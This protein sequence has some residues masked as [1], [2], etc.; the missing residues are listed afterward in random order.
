MISRGQPKT[1]EGEFS[2]MIVEGT[3]YEE[4]KNAGYVILESCRAMRS[5]NKVQMVAY[6]GFNM[7]LMFNALSREYECILKH[8]LSYTVS[9]G[10]DV[11]GNITRLDNALSGIEKKL[12]NNKLELENLIKQEANTREEVKKPFPREQELQEKRVRLN[13][14][15]ALLDVDKKEDEIVNEDLFEDEIPQWESQISDREL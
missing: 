5:P 10:D 15:N 13:E 1:G 6:K 2:G 14:L 11:F 3:F 12:S 4:K 7:Y 9:L 8:S